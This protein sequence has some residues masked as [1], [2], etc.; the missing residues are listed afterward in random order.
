MKISIIVPAYNSEKSIHKCVDSILAQNFNDYE[1]IL[2]DDGSTDKSGVVFD[3]YTMKDI[4][5]SALHNQ[6]NEGL[7]SAV[8]A[9]IKKAQGDFITIV[10]SDDFLDK[11]YLERMYNAVIKNNSDMVFCDYVKHNGTRNIRT[12]IAL[13][14]GGNYD[15]ER[16]LKDFLPGMFNTEL[17]TYSPAISTRH[18]AKLFKAD[19]LKAALRIYQRNSIDDISELLTISA[20]LNSEKITYLKNEYLYYY[21]LSPILFETDYFEKWVTYFNNVSVI[22][23]KKLELSKELYYFKINII[24]DSVMHLEK[25]IDNISKRRIINKIK[26]ITDSEFFISF[27]PDKEKKLNKNQ[28]LFL[29]LLKHKL[30]K[31][32][33]YIL[34]FR[35]KKSK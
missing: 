27:E 1:I 32:I 20:L 18:W 12:H 11:Y 16:V 8:K 7:S 10:D 15:K 23:G 21:R 26:E 9:G 6:Y 28:K 13:I 29:F 34:Y 4:R 24:I 35:M 3:E 5:I 30:F 25:Y 2:V 22:A 31:I 17:N 33:Y 19:I 14:E